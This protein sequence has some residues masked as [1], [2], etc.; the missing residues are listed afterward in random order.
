M[1]KKIMFGRVFEL[2]G[3]MDFLK[4]F[5]RSFVKSCIDFS[6]YK[7]WQKGGVWGEER[8]EWS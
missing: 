3:P 7:R 4:F 6:A 2:W 8:R 1:H 5:F